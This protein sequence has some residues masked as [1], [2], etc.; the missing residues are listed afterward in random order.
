MLNSNH[1]MLS[2]ILII[3]LQSCGKNTETKITENAETAQANV[4]L[5]E[6]VAELEKEL[7]SKLQLGEKNEKLQLELKNSNDAKSK[8]DQ[9]LIFA[10]ARSLLKPSELLLKLDEAI[11]ASQ[12]DTTLSLNALLE[13][14]RSILPE[15]GNIPV[16]CT[17]LIDST[18]EKG[19]LTESEGNGLKLEATAP[20]FLK[21]GDISSKL[22]GIAPCEAVYNSLFN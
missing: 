4:L 8:L 11:L 15:N 12:G 22:V 14:Y 6:R 7:E 5:K 13:F 1:L 2:I 21:A 9:L 18:V 16:Y 19:L 20:L 17:K 3:G 10:Q